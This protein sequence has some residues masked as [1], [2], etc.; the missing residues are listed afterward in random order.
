MIHVQIR[1]MEEGKEIS[2]VK[3][4]IKKTLKKINNRN[5]SKRKEG[6]KIRKK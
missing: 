3:T 2:E 5:K 4:K 1:E 6:K